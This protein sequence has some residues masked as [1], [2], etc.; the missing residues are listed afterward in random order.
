MTIEAEFFEE[1]Q[2]HHAFTKSSRFRL[3]RRAVEFRESISR[4]FQRRLFVDDSTSIDDSIV[5]DNHQ[6]SAKK[7]KKRDRRLNRRY[8]IFSSFDVR[9]LFVLTYFN[10]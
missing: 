2:H 6:S 8:D 4:K 7:T 3:A 1:I 5:R 9:F 10:S